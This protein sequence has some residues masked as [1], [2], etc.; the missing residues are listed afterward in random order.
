MRGVRLPAVGLTIALALNG[1]T[2]PSGAADLMTAGW[3]WRAQ[4][5]A[6]ALPPPPHVPPNGLS[7]GNAPDG[8]S[9][10]AAVRFA[11][12]TDERD[13]VLTLAVAEV[14]A[15]GDP[16]LVACPAAAPWFGPQAGAWEERPEAA[17]TVGTVNGVESAD[18][19]S[20]TFALSALYGDGLLDVV[21]LP[22]EDSDP[23]E[24]SFEAP[25]AESLRTTRAP[26]SG[27]FTPGF[28]TTGS[29]GEA[30]FV[31]P[32]GFGATDF[33]R[34]FSPLAP[35]S[36][37][38]GQAAPA[39][40]PPSDGPR[41]LVPIAQGTGPATRDRSDPRPLALVILLAAL[42]V[43]VSLGREALPAPRLLGPMAQRR[44]SDTQEAEVRGLG[45]FRSPRRGAPPSL[46]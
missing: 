8:P 23:F 20:W 46:H 5:G 7:V 6:A 13:P 24:M 30:S 17:C 3:W 18:G 9:A 31:P 41:R 32:S 44:D 11:L 34:P 19:A 14:F 42:A 28:D 45:R 43:A 27:E 37:P 2:A 1:W 26:E 21:I 22:A 38:P 35:P 15:A 39:E 36:P 16:A 12:Q 4:T 40:A 29:G 33:G 10:V 25:T